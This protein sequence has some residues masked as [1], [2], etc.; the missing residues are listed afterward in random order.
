[1][2][3]KHKRG[4]N[5]AK[6]SLPRSDTASYES[7]QAVEDVLVPVKTGRMRREGRIAGGEA[8]GEV[9]GGECITKL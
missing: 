1:M 4:T 6:Y 2:Y 7:G 8:E 3:L 5:Y 9:A